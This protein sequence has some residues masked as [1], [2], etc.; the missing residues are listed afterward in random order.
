M[1]EIQRESIAWP[2][3]EQAREYLPKALCQAI[4]GDMRP[5]ELQMNAIIVDGIRQVR[6]A[7]TF[8]KGQQLAQ[9]RAY[10]I[11]NDYV[12]QM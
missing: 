5:L 7:E 3:P 2:W 12:R 9:P 8:E 10:E 4:A 6:E 11:E 1:S